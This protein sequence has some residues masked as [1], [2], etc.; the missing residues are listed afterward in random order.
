MRR[1]VFARPIAALLLAALTPLLLDGCVSIGLRRERAAARAA[2]TGSLEVFVFAKPGDERRGALASL[3]VLTELER[4]EQGGTRT[5]ARS[6]ASS[7]TV[8]AL[9]PGRYR[10]RATHRIN[11]RGDVEVLGHPGEREFDLAAG[12]TAHC[13]VVLGKVPVFW[14]VVA[15]VTVVALVILAIQASRHSDW[16]QPPLPPLVPLP[17]LPHPVAVDVAFF[18]QFS[19][20]RTAPARPDVVDSFPRDG[21]RGVPRRVT[22]SFL[23]NRP[24][25]SD[26]VGAGAFLALGT[27]SGPVTGVASYRPAEQMIAFTP[28]RDLEPGE[29]VTVTLDLEKLRSPDGA[30]GE[31]KASIAFTVAGGRG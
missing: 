27:K 3:P 14:I 4:V 24:L 30:R 6:M 21:S 26:G 17:P 1:A 9:P 19:T 16:P 11:A 25:A 13:S 31:G 20:G 23:L 5:V 2:A 8:S 28:D 29:T 10:L 12:E 7:W 15:A 22:V 18:A